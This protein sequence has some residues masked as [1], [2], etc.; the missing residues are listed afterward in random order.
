MTITDLVRKLDVEDK[1]FVTADEIR[2]FSK[3]SGHSYDN[4]T[5]Y[6]EEQNY[7]QRIFRGIFYVMPYR[8][9]HIHGKYNHLELIAKG[10]KI[11]GVENW[12]CGL[13]TALKFNNMTHETFVIDD[14]ISDSVF[15]QQPITIDNHKIQF[16][17]ISKKLT[18]FGIKNN[19]I[20]RYSDPEKTILDFIYLGKYNGKPN[21]R[22]ISDVYDWSEK[23]SE[24]KIKKYSKFYPKTTRDIVY[25]VLHERKTY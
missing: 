18:N 9:Q 6:L 2:K 11:K 10:L 8:R 21:K 4:I 25:E 17:K 14:I 24:E 22:I 3:F 12:Y 15:R 5:K 1:E 20:I 13:H 7:L 23:I 16:R 19:G